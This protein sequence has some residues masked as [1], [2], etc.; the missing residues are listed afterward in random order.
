M[1]SS[2]S[3]SNL[4]LPRARWGVVLAGGLVLFAAFAALLEM[5]LAVRGF[6]PS[7]IDSAPL[8]I[9]ERR[10]VDTLGTRALIL[11]GSSRVLLDTDL[12]VLRME[13][14]LEPVQLAVDGS[15]FVPVLRDLAGDPEV[16][17]TVLVDLAQNVLTLPVQYDAAYAYETAYQRSLADPLPDFSK[18]EAYLAG[19]LRGHLR[20]YS[21]GARPLTALRTRVL[22]NGPTPQYLRMLP[23][24]EILADYS[25]VPQ[26]AFYYARVIRNLGQAVPT[27]GRSYRDIETDFSKRIA[28]LK[29]YD[30]TLFLQALPAM[31]EMTRS[32]QAHGGRVIYATYPTGGY[33]RA[34]DDKRFPRDLFWDRFTAAVYAPHLNFEDVPALRSFYLPDGSHL[35]YHERARFTE[36]LVRSLGLQPPSPGE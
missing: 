23:D 21:D 29:P 7:V 28:T 1:P 36:A 18:S 35:D 24:R 14:G 17:G 22:A 15:S 20:S 11:V 5:R 9:K 12:E 34:M 27:E 8:W 3:S 26:P 31:A 10:R 16:K 6:K 30:N 4:R 25:Q 33:V 13:T 32:I 2:T 19:I